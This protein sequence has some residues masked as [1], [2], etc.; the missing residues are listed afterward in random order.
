MREIKLGD[1]IEEYGDGI[2]G[3][4]KYDEEGE[5]Y[6]VNGNNFEDDKVRITKDTLKI[7]RDEYEK[8]KRPLNNNTLL[9]S[10]NGTLGKIAIYNGEKIALGKS[11]CYLNVKDGVNKYFI[12]YVLS[13][14]EFQKYIRLVAHGSTIKNLAP[15]QIVDYKF[16]APDVADQNKLA[17][18]LKSIDDKIENNKRINVEL[19]AMAKCI[20]NYW[21]LQFD[22]PDKNGK[23]YKSSGG[24]MVWNEDLKKEIPEG[25]EVKEI[26]S[27]VEASRGISYNSSTL[28]G[29]G[30]PM[31]NLASFNVDGSYKMSGIKTYSGEYTQDKILKPYDLVMCNTQQTAIDYRKDIIGKTILVP[32][33]FEGDI[34]SSHHVTTIKVMIK[35]MK[36]YLNCLFN[37]TF[38]H[39]YISGFTNGTNILGLLFDGVEKYKV[40][41]PSE[42]L[43]ER[44]SAF[45]SNIEEQ[46]SLIMRENQELTALRDFLLPLLMNGQ[47][48]F[49]EE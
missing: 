46:K 12:K 6:F 43:L 28:E 9:L 18:L 4:P 10:I 26:G 24:K 21:F 8:I 47:V 14:L 15:S 25:W 49:K 37:T 17:N 19:E 33:I 2:H 7:T 36:F 13:S 45:I 39:K 38:F 31:I 32:D 27:M 35:N 34:V 40:A 5:Y 30:V 16:D 11:A 1:L 29:K 3:T 41:V 20:Y 23:P 22:F 44:F 48:G 42:S